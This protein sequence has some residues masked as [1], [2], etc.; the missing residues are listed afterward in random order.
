MSILYSAIKVI[1]ASGYR[2]RYNGYGK[3]ATIQSIRQVIKGAVPGVLACNGCSRDVGLSRVWKTNKDNFTCH[4]A[5]IQ[6]IRQ[7]IKGAV[8][9]VLGCSRDVGLSRV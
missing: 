7:M 1:D 2:P 6:S 9:S 5:T 3:L 8:P 4:L